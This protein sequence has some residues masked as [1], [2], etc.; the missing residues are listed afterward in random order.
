MKRFVI[1]LIQEHEICFSV[2]AANEVNVMNV[3]VA[4]KEPMYLRLD[5][6]PVLQDVS[7]LIARRMRWVEDHVVLVH[8][9]SIFVRISSLQCR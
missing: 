8:L 4:L 5:D 2:V 6:L 9:V 1:V 3:F 7:V